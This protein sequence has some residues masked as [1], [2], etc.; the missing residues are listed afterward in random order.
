MSALIEKQLSHYHRHYRCCHRY[1]CHHHHHQEG[2][3]HKQNHHR[4]KAQS[5]SKITITNK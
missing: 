1:R 2:Q 5:Y 3:Q 4:K